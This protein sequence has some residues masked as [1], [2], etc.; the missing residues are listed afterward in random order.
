MWSPKTNN[1]SPPIPL[2]TPTNA[3]YRFLVRRGPKGHILASFSL[4]SIQWLHIYLPTLY[5]F[6][7]SILLKCRIYD[8]KVLHT[9]ERERQL[10]AQRKRQRNATSFTHKIKN[11]L[12]G[13]S[14][15]KSMKKA[16][17]LEYF[18]LTK[19]TERN[20]ELKEKLWSWLLQLVVLLVSF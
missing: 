16:R 8:P 20:I 12:T 11:K 5:K 13:S 7:A 17:L 1:N 6:M 19:K 14:S 3:Y 10:A 9:K 4:L 18:I 15:K 2:A